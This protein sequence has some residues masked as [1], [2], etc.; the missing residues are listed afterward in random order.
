MTFIVVAAIA[1]AVFIVFTLASRSRSADSR[2]VPQITDARPAFKIVSASD[3][4]P[5]ESSEDAAFEKVFADEFVGRGMV[6]R[7]FHSTIAGVNFSNDDGS[8]RQKIAAKCKR[9]EV[10][11]LAPEPTNSHDKNAVLVMRSSGEILGHVKRDF[12]KEIS[13]KIWCGEKWIAVIKSVGKGHDVEPV[14]VRIV[15]CKLSEKWIQASENTREGKY[16][17]SV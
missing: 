2:V 3:L 16:V 14:G 10:L 5:P 11:L 17:G 15:L 6:E 8:S 12:A 13:N 7:H 4:R 9:F 1:V